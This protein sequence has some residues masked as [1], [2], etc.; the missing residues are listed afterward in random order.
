MGATRL[1]LALLCLLC[2]RAS[3]SQVDSVTAQLLAEVNGAAD[4][5]SSGTKTQRSVF[6]HDHYSGYPEGYAPV[7][8]QD[9]YHAPLQFGA[10]IPEHPLNEHF[11]KLQKAQAVEYA[12]IYNKH[13]KL[14]YK[15]KY[16]EYPKYKKTKYVA[17]PEHSYP[18]AHDPYTTRPASSPHYAPPAPAHDPYARL[19]P[20]APFP[21]HVTTPPAPLH[22]FPHEPRGYTEPAF[23]GYRLPESYHVAP[24]SY[25]VTEE[26]HVTETY[27]VVEA[28]VPPAPPVYRRPTHGHRA[29]KALGRFS[30]NP[31]PFIET[32]AVAYHE[33]E[34]NF[35]S[36]RQPKHHA[37]PPEGYPAYRPEYAPHTPEYAPPHA[38]EYMAPHA[39]E[40]A[41]PHAQEYV[42]PH[43]QE[44]APPHAQEYAQPHA[45][46]YVAPHA[47]DGPLP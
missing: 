45:Q 5:D 7:G 44:Y 6:H 9:P 40:Y 42:A 2:G 36:R 15:P 30:F 10:R 27:P 17:K 32:I 34:R 12:P 26:F 16:Y 11:R 20:P 4:T 22:K 23:R 46:E 31:E 13:G 47:Q 37:P 39:Q 8:Y 18:P 43:A 28:Y 24:E 29:G 19:P 1:P 35:G 33:N 25:H 21:V 41:P 3:A 14:H 38:Q